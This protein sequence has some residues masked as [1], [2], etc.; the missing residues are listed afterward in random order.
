MVIED[1]KDP[2]GWTKENNPHP[3]PDSVRVYPEPDGSHWTDY[4]EYIDYDN[5]IC[6]NCIARAKIGSG[7]C[8]NGGEYFQ[9]LPKDVREGKKPYV[10]PK[11]TKQS[12]LF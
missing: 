10:K 4:M 2:R 3:A 6:H 8:V 5:L 11:R 12:T 7:N 9:C 1:L